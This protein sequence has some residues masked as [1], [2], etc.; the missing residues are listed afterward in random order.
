MPRGVL[1]GA[2]LRL[3]LCIRLCLVT[4]LLAAATPVVRAADD[5]AMRAFWMPRASLE[6]PDAVRRAIA[7]AVAAGVNTIFVPVS[8]S[9]AFPAGFDGV[10]DAIREASTRA[11][12]VHAWLDVNRAAGADELPGARDHVLYQ[13]PEWLMVPRDLAI[14]LLHVDTRSPEYLGRLARWTRAHIEQADALFLS[15]LDPGVTPYLSERVTALL[16]RYQVQ[17][18]HLD[19]VR[20][21][22]S[23]FD[24]SRR[25]LDVFRTEIRSGLS[26]AERTRMDDIEALDPFAYPEEFPDRWRQ[27][28]QARLT[29]LVTSVAATVRSV[30]P[31]VRITAGITPDAELALREHLQ[32][33]RTWIDRRYVDALL[34]SPPASLPSRPGPAPAG[35]H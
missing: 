1:S 20:F 12:R 21:P 27:F 7:A 23:G 29:A 26:A 10:A 15:P 30:R 4:A 19:T 5:P 14:A 25:A 13:H 17:G 28:R 11:L 31:D 9:S 32:D 24:Y 16:A 34:D 6:S 8:L 35:S 3:A 22:G 33:W 18:V 2:S